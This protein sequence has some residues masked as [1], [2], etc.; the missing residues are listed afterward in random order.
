M[1]Q[2]ANDRSRPAASLAALLLSS[3]TPSIQQ[4]QAGTFACSCLLVGP[5][6]GREVPDFGGFGGLTVG[7]VGRSRHVQALHVTL[8]KKSKN[9]PHRQRKLNQ[10]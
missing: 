7:S 6:R 2:R 5:Y 4:G 9:P 10:N 1:G 3:H 8:F